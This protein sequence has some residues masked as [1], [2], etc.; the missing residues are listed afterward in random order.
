MQIMKT[1]KNHNEIN[2]T[3]ENSIE[4]NP[5]L[6]NRLNN[7]EPPDLIHKSPFNNIISTFGSFSLISL[8]IFF[9]IIFLLQMNRN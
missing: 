8:K 1:N 5:R 2:D 3:I 9:L 4:I 7:N 6:K